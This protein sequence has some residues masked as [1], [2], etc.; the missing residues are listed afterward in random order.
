MVNAN[1]GTPNRFIRG[2]AQAIIVF[3]VFCA[4]LVWVQRVVRPTDVHHEITHRSI[5]RIE[6]IPRNSVDVVF[7][8]GS[9]NYHTF[10]PIELFDTYGIASIQLGSSGQP[11][12]ASYQVL[13]HTL[14]FHKPQVVVLDINSLLGGL[15]ESWTRMVFDSLPL[16]VSKIQT[17]LS[18]TKIDGTDSW[19]SYLFPIM[20]YNNNWKGVRERSFHELNNI[21]IQSGELY[22]HGT[23]MN[24]AKNGKDALPLPDDTGEE[25]VEPNPEALTYLAK[26]RDLCAKNGIELLL[27]QPPHTYESARSHNTLKAIAEA[28]NLEFI[29]FNLASTQQEA[30]FDYADGLMMDS[31]HL[32]TFGAIIATRYIGSKLGTPDRRGDPKYQYLADDIPTWHHL[33][34]LQTLQADQSAL[35]SYLTMAASDPN[36]DIFITAKDEATSGMSG[37][38][39]ES[40]AE[41]GFSADFNGKFRH[42]YI[43][44]IS[45]GEVVFEE[46]AKD[47]KTA[48]KHEFT[49]RDG[50]KLTIESAGMD[51]GNKSVVLDAS[52]TNRSKNAR[53]LNVVVYDNLL[54]SIVDSI[55]WDTHVAEG[56]LTSKR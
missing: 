12:I 23:V 2:A 52:G 45:G 36:F 34:T 46:L 8:G 55:S 29:N 33:V 3:A 51:C 11:M 13:F 28:N 38:L 25:T 27:F 43:G 56:E 19:M 5:A 7:I 32:N 37:E 42:S 40:F 22:W 53:G 17:I 44:I 9:D 39:K 50:T 10:S 20:R 16:S 48:L 4:L 21:V 49:T 26:I 47:T 15:N 54:H 1:K 14:K 18:H 31:A 35:T 6:E 41:L 24:R 30:G